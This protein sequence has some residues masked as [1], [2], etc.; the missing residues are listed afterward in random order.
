M[1]N[2]IILLATL[3]LA[4]AT[5]AQ[6]KY[7]NTLICITDTEGYYKKIAKNLISSGIPL[8]EKDADL[9]YIKSDIIENKSNLL[10]TTKAEYIFDLY[11]NYFTS[12]INGYYVGITSEDVKIGYTPGK[13]SHGFAAFDRLINIVSDAGGCDQ[14]IWKQLK[15]GQS[16]KPFLEE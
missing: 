16:Y 12:Y 6:K 3:L 1:K 7:D 13:K 15:S 5:T 9:G 4:T 14:W 8:A 10:G 2:L 11:D